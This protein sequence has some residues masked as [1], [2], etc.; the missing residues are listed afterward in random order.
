MRLAKGWME[1]LSDE[2]ENLY[3]K[4]LET[5]LAKEYRERI[6]YPKK[7]NIFR[8][9]DLTDYNAVKVCILGQDPYINPNQANGLAFAVNEGVG[10]PPSLL[11]IFKEIESIYGEKP[12]STTLEG[13]AEQGVLLLNTV[14]TVR[15][16]ES[17]SHK[18]MGWEVFTDK[19]I[20]ILGEREDPIIF[21]LWGN[22]AINKKRLI[23][24]H[25][26][27]LTSPHPS[28]LSAYRGFFGCKHF[29]EA[30]QILKKLSKTE[31]NWI[32]SRSKNA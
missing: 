4:K 25:H 18:D 32:K 29:S 24:E 22:P 5:F 10:P 28:P 6:I 31:I 21:I 20:E 19:I 26:H 8:A 13:W 3:I 23:K 14:L 11:N 9:F 12:E 17:N 27:V 2:F 30:N 15:A 16:G 7:D 1:I